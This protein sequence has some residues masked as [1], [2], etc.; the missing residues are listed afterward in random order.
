MVKGIKIVR[1]IRRKRLSVQPPKAKAHPWADEGK[2][3]P[4]RYRAYI[5]D[6][7][8]ERVV[9]HCE[10]QGQTGLEAMGFLSGGVFNWKGRTYTVVKDALTSSLDATAVHVRFERTGFPGLFGQLDRLDY[11][12]II[13]GWYHSHPGYGCFMSGTDQETQS[14]GFSEPFH[15]ALVVDPVKKEMK[16]F[17]MAKRLRAGPGNDIVAPFEEVAFGIYDEY[18]WP[19]PGPKKRTGTGK[20]H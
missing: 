20:A 10:K 5:T 7:A 18:E 11:E 17:R 2:A 9:A 12:Y 14:A 19:W 4:R 3:R 6:K 13:V 8:I 16:S 15:L 1:E